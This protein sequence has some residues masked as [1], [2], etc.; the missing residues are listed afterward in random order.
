MPER[1]TP[2]KGYLLA[3]IGQAVSS[4]TNMLAVVI[5]AR[6]L[7]LATFGEFAL[8][9]S[10]YPAIVG[11]SRALAGDP[12]V[13]KYT[14]L[15][16]AEFREQQIRSTGVAVTIGSTFSLA[17][18]LVAFSIGAPTGSALV[19]LA[20]VMPGACL[21][22]H[23]RLVAFSRGQGGIALALD[24]VWLVVQAATMLILLPGDGNAGLPILCWGIGASSAGLFAGLLLRVWP[25]I[26]ATA[27]WLSTH[28]S[29]WPRYVLEVMLLYGLGVAVTFVL[30]GSVNLEQVAAYRGGQLLLSGVVI[31]TTGLSLISLPAMTVAA[32]D[33]SS[34]V[35]TVVKS[36]SAWLATASVVSIL[37]VAAIPEDLG[38]SI[39]GSTWS[40]SKSVG[41]LL[42]IASLA[43]VP[44]MVIPWAMRASGFARLSLRVRFVS[45]A[46]R[47][48]ITIP[49]ATVSAV[50]VGWASVL[51]GLISSA[52]WLLAWRRLVRPTQGAG[53]PRM[54]SAE[55]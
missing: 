16:N 19:G 23:L 45:V 46:I 26:L 20:M 11:I 29:V 5:A 52:V 38:R 28:T 33:S 27:S 51:S 2:V 31:A 44:A 14:A 36:V 1:A 22:E 41:T 15:G 30:A 37:A 25:N 47:G 21:A 53:R 42:L 39:L 10:V 48:L 34:K 18:V 8:L 12:L 24:V 54:P 43:G 50:W 9:F 32:A 6:T 7:D 40:C 17:M 55:P 13:V 49:A 35:E 3:V 4:G